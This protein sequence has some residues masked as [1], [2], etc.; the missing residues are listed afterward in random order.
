M[1]KISHTYKIERL[2]SVKN[3][4]N[5]M[6]VMKIVVKNGIFLSKS[7]NIFTRFYNLE[8]RNISI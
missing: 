3:L 4:N 1:S 2:Q 7:S 6:P 8:P 5:F